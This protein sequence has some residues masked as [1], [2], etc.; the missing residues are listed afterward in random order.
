VRAT[1]LVGRPAATLTGD[2]EYAA[3]RA[4]ALARTEADPGVVPPEWALWRIEA[5]AVEFW[6]A[7]HDRA[8]IR[9]R[10]RRDGD[11]WRRERLWP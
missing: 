8:H 3:A 10:Y 4:A 5:D 1:A 2:Q 6:Q 9:L 11:A 7:A